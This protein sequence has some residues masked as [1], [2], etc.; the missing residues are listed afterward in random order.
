MAKDD[1]KVRY[2]VL[3]RV[4]VNGSFVDP[5]GRKDVYVF[6]ESGL[7]GPA[8]RLA[9]EGKAGAAKDDK[10]EAPAGSQAAAAA[11]TAG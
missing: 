7:E 4:F 1:K 6:A 2:Q 11:K 8:L 3:G 10:T 5:K 9:P